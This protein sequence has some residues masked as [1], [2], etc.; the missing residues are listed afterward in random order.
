MANSLNLA[1]TA[2]GVEDQVQLDF[3]RKRGCLEVQGRLFGEAMNAEEMTKFLK[4]SKNVFREIKPDD[5]KKPH[6]EGSKEIH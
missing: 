6:F 4:S 1:V 5:R 3:L 2:V